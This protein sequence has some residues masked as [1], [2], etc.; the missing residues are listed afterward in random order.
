LSSAL[1][2]GDRKQA[3]VGADIPYNATRPHKLAGKIEQIRLDFRLPKPQAG[4]G[5]DQQRTGPQVGWEM[6]FQ[7]TAPAESLYQIAA[8]SK[9]HRKSTLLFNESRPGHPSRRNLAC[10]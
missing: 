3:N 1:R 8:K 10:Y 7:H 6:P 9:V 2:S 5:R 4:V